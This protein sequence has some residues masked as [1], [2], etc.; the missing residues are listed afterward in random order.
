VTVT[1]YGKGMTQKEIEGR[2]RESAGS[3]EMDGLQHAGPG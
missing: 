1:D 3:I 2:A